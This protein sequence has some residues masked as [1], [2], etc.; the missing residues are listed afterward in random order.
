MSDDVD[1]VGEWAEVSD[2]Q[3]VAVG[4]GGEGGTRDDAVPAVGGAGLVDGHDDGDVEG[5]DGS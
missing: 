2:V 3:V 1:A 4:F 5:I